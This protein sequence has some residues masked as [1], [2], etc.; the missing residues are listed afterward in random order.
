V[1]SGGPLVGIDA[2]DIYWTRGRNVMRM[3]LDGGLPVTIVTA[4]DQGPIG[5]VTNEVVVHPTGVYWTDIG[6][7][8]VFRFDHHACECACTPAMAGPCSGLQVTTCSPARRYESVGC[9]AACLDSVG[10]IAC[11]P[12]AMDCNGNTPQ[13]CDTTGHWNLLAPCVNQSCVNGQCIGVCDAHSAGRCQCGSAVVCNTSGQWNS[14]S[15]GSSACIDYFGCGQFGCGIRDYLCCSGPGPGCHAGLRCALS[16]N[17]TTC[18]IT[19]SC[20]CTGGSSPRCVDY[21]SDPRLLLADAGAGG[22]ADCGTMD[23]GVLGD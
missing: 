13:T 1:A 12:G 8:G 22:G 2:T 15:C 7:G 21:P 14:V 19:G 3:P 20:T 16:C 6:R 18:D 11:V 9:S 4:E 5:A 23:G 10:C 17:Q